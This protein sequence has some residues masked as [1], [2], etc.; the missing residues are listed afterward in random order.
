MAP[1]RR[2][3][4]SPEAAT[5]IEDVLNSHTEVMRL[6]AD[7]R[8]ATVKRASAVTRA[9]QLGASQNEIAVS[10]GIT[11]ETVRLWGTNSSEL[12]ATDVTKRRLEEL[13][14]ALIDMRGFVVSYLSV[15]G[16]RPHPPD[17]N[18][19]KFIG[20]CDK[21]LA[22]LDALGEI[23]NGRLAEVRHFAEGQVFSGTVVNQCLF[24][25]QQALRQVGK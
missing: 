11:G 10:L 7:R 8:A 9:L 15:H 6:E 19:V 23:E 1:Y 14:G 17:S 3:P 16:D 2:P 12:V 25:A 5:A 22:K 18:A 4:I 13:I 21:I 24:A 20:D